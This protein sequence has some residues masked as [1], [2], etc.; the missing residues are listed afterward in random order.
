M[1]YTLLG[2]TQVSSWTDEFLKIVQDGPNCV[3]LWVRLVVGL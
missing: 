1:A 2:K 3:I